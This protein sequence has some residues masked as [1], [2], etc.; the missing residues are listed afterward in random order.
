VKLY[1]SDSNY[2][3][4]RNIP[5]SLYKGL[6]SSSVA[7]LMT[8]I[9][10]QNHRP[11]NAGFSRWNRKNQLQPGQE[12]IGNA[13]VVALF[14]DKNQLQPGQESIGN[15]GVVALFFDKK[16]PRTKPTGVLQHCRDG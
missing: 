16:N 11:F 15:A 13:S 1:T 5:G 6:Y 9:A 3:D 4:V 12:S 14:F 2:K 7:F 10:S 8:S